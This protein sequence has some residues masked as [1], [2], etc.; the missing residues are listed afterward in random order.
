M[1][2]LLGL[3]IASFLEIE[4]YL[5]ELSNVHTFRVRHRYLSN[6]EGECYLLQNDAFVLYFQTQTF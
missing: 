5:V 3:D 4:I 2:I 1:S 6:M